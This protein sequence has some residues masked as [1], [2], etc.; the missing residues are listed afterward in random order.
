MGLPNHP[1][2]GEYQVGNFAAEF[3]RGNAHYFPRW[4]LCNVN[5]REKEELVH[6]WPS[7]NNRRV[8]QVHRV[9][10]KI[11]WRTHRRGSVHLHLPKPSFQVMSAQTPW[12]SL[13]YTPKLSIKSLKHTLNSFKHA[14]K[15]R[16][17]G[18]SSFKHS[19]KATEH[20]QKAIEDLQTAI[21]KLQRPVEAGLFSKLCQVK[22]YLCYCR[23]KRIKFKM[24]KNEVIKQQWVVVL[25]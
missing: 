18:P 24:V 4:S 10:F 8:P 23:V 21:E 7:S 17:H 22:K 16:K 1:E 2:A 6:D 20:S 15:S 9:K 5:L 14:H 11:S 13:L 12:H 19:W 3:R 25:Q